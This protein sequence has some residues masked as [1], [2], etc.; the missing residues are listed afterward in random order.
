MGVLLFRLHTRKKLVCTIFLAPHRYS[1]RCL[2]FY[3]Y[4]LSILDFI[5]L[6]RHYRRG[7]LFDFPRGSSQQLPVFSLS[8]RLR[9]ENGRRFFY[10]VATAVH[11]EGRGTLESARHRSSLDSVIYR[12]LVGG[13]RSAAARPEFMIFESAVI[14]VY[15]EKSLS[16]GN[17]LPGIFALVYHT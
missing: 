8:V 9:R 11:G 5:F 4:S 3:F 6:R 2:R 16:R 7:T 12:P 15:S 13:S 10:V 17:R 1:Q 14:V